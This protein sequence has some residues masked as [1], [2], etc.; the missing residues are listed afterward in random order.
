MTFPV[1]LLLRSASASSDLGWAPVGVAGVEER[2]T[3][4]VGDISATAHVLGGTLNRIQDGMKP[5]RADGGRHRR[6][7]TGSACSRARFFSG[8]PVAC[9]PSDSAFGTEDGLGHLDEA[10]FPFWLIAAMP[11][12]Y[13]SVVV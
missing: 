2:R 13:G 6:S 1:A 7:R 9:M 10:D 5:A 11:V 3:L 8:T 4:Q 12:E